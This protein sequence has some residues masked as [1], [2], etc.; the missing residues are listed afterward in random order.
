MNSLSL[1]CYS[2]GDEK[3]GNAEPFPETEEK[4]CRAGTG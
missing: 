3:A 1:E 2:R 4:Y